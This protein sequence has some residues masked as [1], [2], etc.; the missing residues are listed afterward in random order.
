MVLRLRDTGICMREIDILDL[1]IITV[2]TR[3]EDPL[4][5]QYLY[6]LEALD[7]RR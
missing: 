2:E 6:L 1:I 7:M 5:R 4:L 3:L